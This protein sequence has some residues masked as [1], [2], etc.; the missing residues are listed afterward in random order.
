MFLERVC[1]SFGITKERIEEKLWVVV[2][3]IRMFKYPRLPR[4]M[5]FKVISFSTDLDEM[6]VGDF[7][8][9]SFQWDERKLFVHLL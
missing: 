5:T 1:M 6:K 7:I 4:P 9:T 8:T 2:N 3:H